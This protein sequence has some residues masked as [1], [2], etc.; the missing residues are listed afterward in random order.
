MQFKSV[1]T[2]V[3]YHNKLNQNPQSNEE[4]DDKEQTELTNRV[5]TDMSI[6]N[7]FQCFKGQAIN[8]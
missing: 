4:I 6:F 7:L 1:L 8:E 3:K 5:S 2:S